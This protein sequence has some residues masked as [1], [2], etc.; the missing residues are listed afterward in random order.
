MDKVSKKKKRNVRAKLSSCFLL[1]YE[2]LKPGIIL[3]LCSVKWNIHN[4]NTA[5]NKCHNFTAFPCLE[6]LWKRIVSAEFRANC[7]K[8]CR[9][10]SRLCRN[11]AFLQHFQT[12]KLGEILVF[13]AVK[14]AKSLKFS[15]KSLQKWNNFIEKLGKIFF[16]FFFSKFWRNGVILHKWTFK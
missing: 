2:L 16:N 1:N 4:I 6:I 3:L 11:S 12:T 13:Y 8:L 14:S 10:C 9:N 5:N 7:S 15:G